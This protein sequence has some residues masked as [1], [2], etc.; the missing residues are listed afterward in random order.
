RGSLVGH[1]GIHRIALLQ[2]EQASTRLDGRIKIRRG[3]GQA[4]EAEG[5][6]GIGLLRRNYAA[7]WP[8]CA[9]VAARECDCANYS[10]AIDDGCPHLE[11]QARGFD[12]D[13]PGQG[14]AERRMIWQ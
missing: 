11:V 1:A 14:L 7:A 6:R 8:L 5:V 12:R 13:S 2:P 9:A 3:Q 10:V 4:I